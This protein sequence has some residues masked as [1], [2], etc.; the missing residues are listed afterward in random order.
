MSKS[1]SNFTLPLLV[2][3]CLVLGL[4]LRLGDPS[5][6]SFINDELSTW[7]KV[8]YGSVGDVIANIKAVDSHPVGMYVFVYYWTQLFGTSEWA[9]KLPFFLLSLL[10]LWLIFRVGTLWF[11]KSTGVLVLAAWATLQFP[12]W[13]SHIAR[14]YQSG[15]VLTL[16]LVYCW[17]QL[18]LY[19]RSEKRY[20]IG[21]VTLGALAC[22]NHYFSAL[23][24]GIVGV[25]GV[26]LIDRKRW[27]HYLLSGVLMLGLFMP[28]LPITLYQAQNADGHLWYGVPTPAFF[29]QHVQYLFHY[30]FLVLWVV[31]VIALL[32]A[33][34]SFQQPAI[35]Q[36]A[37]RAL[38]PWTLRLVAGLWF[39]APGLLGYW[40]SVT[41]SPIL[42]QDHLLFSFPFGL[43]LIFSGWAQTRSGLGLSISVL[44]LLGVNTWTLVKHRHHF[45]VVHTHPYEHFI[46]HTKAFLVG[47]TPEEATIVLG[48]NPNY[49]QYYQ[50][51]YNSPFAYESS[52]KPDIAFDQFKKLVNQGRPYFIMGGL[53]KAHEQYALDHYP[54]V[55][56]YA[57][58]VNYEYYIL[59]REWEEGARELERI[60]GEEMPEQP[61]RLSH[62]IIQPYGWHQDSTGT[63]YYE[64]SEEWGP[65]YIGP[66]AGVVPE[67]R[68]VILD[69]GVSV[70]SGVDS[71]PLAGTLVV[72]MATAQDS[73]LLWK[74]VDVAEQATSETGWQRLLLSV[75][76]AHEDL[77][78][79][80]EPLNIRV[81][82]WN[83][84]KQV[85]H[86]NRF[87]LCTRRDNALLYK[88]SRPF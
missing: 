87:E 74:G 23:F 82:F 13:W 12:I 34:R 40:Y 37:D 88:D 30:S 9:I 5:A 26:F 43:L 7:H 59:A 19:R 45:E 61:S 42:R 62:W 64:W 4:V 33:L 15:S 53:P 71:I 28:H 38:S 67:D 39:V 78:N 27:L 54:Y 10:S 47:H 44:L 79:S 77:Y 41:Y 56:N 2:G 75:R 69:V 50:T 6:W 52:F 49:L 18:V 11:S 31:A 25:T 81:F 46:R 17:T 51:T 24:A 16:G 29:I 55:L 3:L 68:H 86:L 73:V 83:R 48:E 63:R 72:E 60:C 36:P 85:L 57:H 58:G 80:D 32:G 14:Q 1:H 8:S 21:W 35:T 22:Y 66:L 84:E 70:R 76:F 65:T 20:W